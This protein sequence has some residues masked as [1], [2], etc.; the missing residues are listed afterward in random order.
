MRNIKNKR[1]SI[2]VK[3][4]KEA[5][6]LYRAC[7]NNLQSAQISL[8]GVL[9]DPYDM[10]YAKEYEKD[11]VEY[12]LNLKRLEKCIKGW[13]KEIYQAQKSYSNREI[14]LHCVHCE[15]EIGFREIYYR[16]KSGRVGFID[17]LG[18]TCVNGNFKRFEK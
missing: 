15:Q 2:A 13:K 5:R 7:K 18:Q 12:R 16:C 9:F 10:K 6:E 17:D 4:L 14:C 3:R 1:H 11:I 8:S